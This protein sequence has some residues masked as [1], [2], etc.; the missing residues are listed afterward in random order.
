MKK[1]KLGI[2]R[3]DPIGFDQGFVNG[4]GKKSII[5]STERTAR[6]LFS[7]GISLRWE[8]YINAGDVIA[9]LSIS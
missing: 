4:L 7:A 1:K 8:E 3:I 5:S 2:G 9:F 6:P